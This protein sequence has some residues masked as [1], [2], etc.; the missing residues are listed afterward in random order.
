MSTK[1]LKNKEFVWSV[2]KEILEEDNLTEYIG[3]INNEYDRIMNIMFRKQLEYNSYTEMNK[4]ILREINNI[5][6]NVKRQKEKPKKKTVRIQEIYNKE[7]EYEKQQS[8]I[9]NEELRQTR[10]T[11]F[12]N[13]LQEKQNDFNNSMMLKPPQEI[14]FSDKMDEDIPNIDKLMEEELK[15]RSYE[16]NNITE[17]YQGNKAEEWIYNGNKPD[18]IEKRKNELNNEHINM[19]L[20]IIENKSIENNN[21]ESK[22]INND[23]QPKS[24]NS[25]LSKL[26]KVSIEKQENPIEKKEEQ[27]G[28]LET[29]LE[30]IRIYLLKNNEDRKIIELNKKTEKYIK[31]INKYK[32]ELEE[33]KYRIEKVILPDRNITY[34]NK[35]LKLSIN[36]NMLKRI[37]IEINNNIY[38]MEREKN[39]EYI[40]K[41]NIE[42]E[43]IIYVS[44]S[45][46]KIQLNP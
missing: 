3:I 21:I 1:W 34:E 5:L 24:V 35:Y 4:D 6:N 12:N 11:Q 33:G 16:L 37:D 14:D 23:E 44:L 27:Q 19:S 7:K 9:T 13:E 29:S 8:P 2:I 39:N 41:E 31:E 38:E 17:Q 46:D 20:E 45:V 42:I 25:F 40:M 43:K 10:N 22:T 36:T 30:K 32:I 26:K 28:S 15:K 18:N